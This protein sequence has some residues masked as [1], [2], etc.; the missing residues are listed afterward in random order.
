[1]ANEQMINS[2]VS[3]INLKINKGEL[4]GIFGSV[5][6]GKTSLLMSMLNELYK[7][8]GI[9]KQNGRISFVG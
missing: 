9:L 1:M 5:G 2:C 7:Q 8:K 6:S 4:I 3:E